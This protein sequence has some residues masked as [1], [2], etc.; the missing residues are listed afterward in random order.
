MASRGLSAICHGFFIKR[1]CF[2][3]FGVV[4]DFICVKPHLIKVDTQF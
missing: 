2:I 1:T 3:K 4:I